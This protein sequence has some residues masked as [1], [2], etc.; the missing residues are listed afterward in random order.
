GIDDQPAVIG[1]GQV[2]TNSDAVGTVCAG[3]GVG[4]ARATRSKADWL[5][6]TGPTPVASSS[7]RF[8]PVASC[9]AEDGAQQG[10]IGSSG[11]SAGGTAQVRSV[12][13]VA[14]RT[15]G[16]RSPRKSGGPCAVTS[17]PP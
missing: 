13:R 3:I 11:E 6:I 8:T 1:F 16:P 7:D 15:S 9:T 17:P 12:P 5:R 4:E 2:A 14:G 10:T